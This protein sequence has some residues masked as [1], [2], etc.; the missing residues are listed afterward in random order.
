M[1]K[2]KKPPADPSPA[3]FPL[4]EVA[5]LLG[6]HPATV[7]RMIKRGDIPVFR[8]GSDYRF[9]RET[10]EALQRERENKPPPSKPRG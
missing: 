6:I 9:N 4:L 3:V 1:A 7:R 10:I 8:V 5:E 2:N